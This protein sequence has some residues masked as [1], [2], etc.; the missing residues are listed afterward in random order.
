MAEVDNDV[1]IKVK[2]ELIERELPWQRG[3][4]TKL[5]CIHWCYDWCFQ[6]SG[7]WHNMVHPW[8]AWTAISKGRKMNWC[9]TSSRPWNCNYIIY[10][11]IMSMDVWSKSA[12][13][14]HLNHHIWSDSD[15][16]FHL[17]IVII[18]PYHWS[19]S[20]EH[21]LDFEVKFSNQ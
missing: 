12:R 8:G 15:I 5:E 19:I 7:K 20:Y 13:I 18:M 16:Y 21:P 2:C 11:Y 9:L 3:S 17:W 10:I 4:W 14:F 1:T 6:C